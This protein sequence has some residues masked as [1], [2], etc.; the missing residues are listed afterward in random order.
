MSNNFKFYLNYII[1]F[2][3]QND[4]I[5][6]ILAVFGVL[7]ISYVGY[8]LSKRIV[9]TIV[10]RVVEKTKNKID[11]TLFTDKLVNHIAYLIPL[12]IIHQFAHILPIVKVMIES[13]S[14]VLIV[15]FILL[16]ISDLLDGTVDILEK[17]NEFKNK[18]IK[19]YSQLI[20]II[21]FIYGFIVIAAIILGEQ[22]WTLLGGLS[23]LTAVLLLIFKD[24]ILSLVAS[25]Q[26]ST[27]DL[28]RKG[29]WIEVPKYNADG[30]VIDISLNVIKIQNWDKTIT[31]IPTYKILEDSFKN[32]R[33]MTISGGRRI[34]RSILIDVN[35]IKF[36]NHNLIEKLKKVILLKDYIEAKL[37]EINRFNQEN[38]IESDNIINGRRLTNIGTFRVYLEN[39][40]KKRTDIRLDMTFLVRQ[41]QSSAQGLPIEVYLF[42][43][44]TKWAEYEKIQ[45]DIF[46]HIFAV[47]N[48]FE[49]KIFQEP[50]GFD[51]S[52]KV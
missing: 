13:V 26:I 45:S 34:K 28:V 1:Q 41:L 8:S 52:K 50:S 12:I 32:W 22:P 11:D 7:I 43:N 29:D 23:A 6:D 16:S 42:T 3:E 15:W 35:S 44:T 19:G 37:I 25:V 31:I 17:T 51:F 40:L 10:R 27:Y 30:D 24:T 47:V 5:L 18:P 4:F 14:E 38:N 39:Y 36:L 9:G 2:L 21:V 20:K 49:L 46:D 48:E 33:G